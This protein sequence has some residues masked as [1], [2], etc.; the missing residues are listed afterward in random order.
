[1]RALQL[2]WVY[3]LSGAVIAAPAA[4]S[5][6]QVQALLTLKSPP[7]GVVFEIVAS[8]NGLVWAIPKV[9]SYVTALRQKFPGI[10]LVV[11]SHGGEQFALQTKK[12][13][14]HK[15]IHAEVSRLVTI[16]GVKVQVCEAH[17]NRRG[18]VVKDF[19]D[20]VT[21]AAHGPQEIRNY[22]EFGYRHIKVS[23]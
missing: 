6:Q 16:D 3:L 12:S 19:P 7:P 4:N 14:I 22:L 2:F 9:R 1:M 8:A 17:A 5:D 21:V 18:V 11:V 23:R 15:T 10:K 13:N 20:Y